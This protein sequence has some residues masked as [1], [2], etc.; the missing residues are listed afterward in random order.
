MR[1][2]VVF[3]I[4]MIMLFIGGSFSYEQEEE[5]FDFTGESVEFCLMQ[6]PPQME[7]QKDLTD[8]I[9]IWPIMCGLSDTKPTP[10]YTYFNA[11]LTHGGKAWVGIIIASYDFRNAS[12]TT[13]TLDVIGPK[14]SKIKQS[15]NIPGNTIM[16]Y[17]WQVN[18]DNY[19]SGLYHVNAVINGS[20]TLAKTLQNRCVVTIY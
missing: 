10:N 2:V 18:L 8:P 12:K 6:L 17:G 3:A 7:A 20:N 9:E 14:V 16:V 11:H 15:K 19:Y 1:N 4:T 13:I 5:D